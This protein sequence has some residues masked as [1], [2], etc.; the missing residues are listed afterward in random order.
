[1]SFLFLIIKI[2]NKNNFIFLYCLC[3]GGS[4]G[5][6]R[7]SHHQKSK[8]SHATIFSIASR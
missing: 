6:I 7:R 5:M 8:S 1:M 4:Y 3:G 2:K